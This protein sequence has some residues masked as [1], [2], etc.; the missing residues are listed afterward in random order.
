M[1][2]APFMLARSVLALSLIAVSAVVPAMAAQL[3]L[4]DTAE[5]HQDNNDNER[6]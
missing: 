4:R 6:S 2:R 1:T 5:Y 3:S